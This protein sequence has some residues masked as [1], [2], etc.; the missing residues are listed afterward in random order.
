MR[1]FIYL[2]IGVSLLVGCQRPP[3]EAPKVIGIPFAVPVS[4]IKHHLPEPAKPEHYSLI[5]MYG[6]KLRYANPENW[7]VIVQDEAPDEL[8]EPRIFTIYLGRNLGRKC[9]R[10]DTS[11]VVIDLQKKYSSAFETTVVRNLNE[12]E[13]VALLA[14]DERRLLSATASCFIQNLGVRFTYID[15]DLY[16][17]LKP[18]EVHI[19]VKKAAIEAKEFKSRVLK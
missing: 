2:S 7:E 6:Y 16:Q 8:K 19:V 18:E 13:A 10:S 1:N 5:P 15:L 17:Y 4:A 12:E 14:V 11:S 9:S 3:R